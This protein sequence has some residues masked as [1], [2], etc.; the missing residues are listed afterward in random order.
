MIILGGKFS[1]RLMVSLFQRYVKY[2]GKQVE[3][4]LP[5]SG[6]DSHIRPLIPNTQNILTIPYADSTP[7]NFGTCWYIVHPVYRFPLMS[8]T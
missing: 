7:A 4:Y 6:V 2:W 5:Y 8:R 1:T 3:Y